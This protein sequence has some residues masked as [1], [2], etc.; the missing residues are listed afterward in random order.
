MVFCVAWTVMGVGI[1]L[2]GIA[3][4]YLASLLIFIAHETGIATVPVFG[5]L[6]IMLFLKS[7]PWLLILLILA[8]VIILELLARHYSFAYRVP[9][10]YSTVVILILVVAGGLV[11]AITPFHKK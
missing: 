2:A 7:L 1:I 6:G 10:I 9:L 4:L 5:W 11:V 3:G 8:F